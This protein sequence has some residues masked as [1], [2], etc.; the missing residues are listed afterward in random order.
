MEA[1][2]HF[3]VNR[4]RKGALLMLVIAVLW[5]AMP[6]AACLASSQSAMRHMCCRGM[7]RACGMRGMGASGSC[8]TTNRRNP[9]AAP[10]PC[11]AP[12]QSQR[13][14]LLP[15]QAGVPLPSA[16]SDGYANTLEAPPLKFPPGTVS[17]LRI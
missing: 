14:A 2:E 11:Y 16:Q 1:R 9:E 3:A 17:I 13:A 12:G 15:L 8:C 7:A 10:V 4:S 5:T 6:A